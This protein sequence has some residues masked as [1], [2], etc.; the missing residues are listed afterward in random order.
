MIF[1][2][3]FVHIDRQEYNLFANSSSVEADVSGSV[4]SK[5]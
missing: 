1:E 4:V 5:E 3:S 2:T